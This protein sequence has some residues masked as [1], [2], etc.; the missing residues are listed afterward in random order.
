MTES[1][2]VAFGDIGERFELRRVEHALRN[3]HAQHLRVDIL[4]LA[5]GAAQQPELPPLLGS[6]L[7]AL[8]LVEHL[9]ERID[10]GGIGKRQPSASVG[11]RIV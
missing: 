8:E 10:V 11:S 9:R 6:D 3:L 5:V 2:R 4:P 7:A 1:A